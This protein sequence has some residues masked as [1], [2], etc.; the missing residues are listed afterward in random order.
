M[1]NVVVKSPE[2]YEVPIAA[3]RSLYVAL[4]TAD[5]LHINHPAGA[6]APG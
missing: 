5:P 1:L 3:N 4:D 6:E 2:P